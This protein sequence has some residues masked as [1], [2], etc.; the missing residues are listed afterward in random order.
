MQ[1]Y[2][3]P[4]FQ[5]RQMPNTKIKKIH[6]KPDMSDLPL[7]NRIIAIHEDNQKSSQLSLENDNDRSL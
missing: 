3:S 2:L 4:A 7:F 5:A 6:E 1:D